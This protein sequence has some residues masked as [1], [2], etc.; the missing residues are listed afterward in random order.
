MELDQLEREVEVD[1]QNYRL[2]LTKIEESRISSAMDS[3]KIA[4]VSLIEPAQPPVKPVSPKVMLNLALGLLLGIFGGLGLAFF[5]EYLDDSL[6]K[7]EQVETALQIPVLA[8]I[9]E[10]RH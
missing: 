1:R 4:N 8:S 2:Y 6:E 10:L 5:T 9:P 7:P 3:E